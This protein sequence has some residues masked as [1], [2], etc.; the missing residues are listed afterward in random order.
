MDDLVNKKAGI[1]M[2]L[3][4]ITLA[5]LWVTSTALA[6]D[7]YIQRGGRSGSN[8]SV[9]RHGDEIS[10]WNHRTGKCVVGSPSGNGYYYQELGNRDNN[11]YIES[12]SDTQF[13]P[14]PGED[15]D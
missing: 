9:E 10:I 3:I 6:E 5:I 12:D 11:V 4:I 14:I 13:L 1:N 2:K 8:I 15:D 7:V